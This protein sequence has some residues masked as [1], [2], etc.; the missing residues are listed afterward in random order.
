MSLITQQTSRR[1]KRRLKNLIKAEVK[2]EIVVKPKSKGRRRRR[3]RV[4]AL[5]KGILPNIARAYFDTLVDPFEYGPVRLGFGT[6]VPT[7]LY[8]AYFRLDMISNA[9]GSFGVACLPSLGNVTQ[10]LWSTN[11]AVNV[12][13]WTAR[14]FANQ[15]AIS[16]S[17][18]EGRVV[19]MGIRVTPLLA[20]T[21]RPGILYTAL[22]PTITNTA[23]TGSSVQTLLNLPQVQPNPGAGVATIVYR[24]VDPNSYHFTPNAIQGY[25][26]ATTPDGSSLAI[27]GTGFPAS[28]ALHV[29]VVLNLESIISSGTS[30]ASAAITNPELMPEQVSDYFPSLEQMWNT[31]RSILP[32]PGSV[33]SSFG[34]A[35]AATLSIMSG[36]GAVNRARQQFFLRTVPRVL[37]EEA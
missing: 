28:T 12:A 20:A 2:Q 10:N 33:A 14:S 13:S 35:T 32:E 22:I 36:M 5:S 1:E 37:I 23:L 9:D 29:D 8:T 26:G 17:A 24:P 11:A 16:S 7:D 19:S 25:A 34:A 3:N 21:D 30:A 6:L 4:R 31:F 15:L 27:L 18:G